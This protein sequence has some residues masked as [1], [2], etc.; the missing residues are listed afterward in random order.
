MKISLPFALLALTGAAVTL[1]GPTT[2]PASRP[3]DNERPWYEALPTVSLDGK[4][5]YRADPEGAELLPDSLRVGYLRDEDGPGLIHLLRY[6]E[7]KPVEATPT[8]YIWLVDVTGDGKPEIV[9]LSSPSQAC[10]AGK[11]IYKLPT[12]DGRV[13]V[14]HQHRKGLYPVY[15]V[16]ADGTLE[17]ILERQGGLGGVSCY[18]SMPATGYDKDG[19]VLGKT[20]Y[21]VT[22]TH[23]GYGWK[24]IYGTG[25]PVPVETRSSKITHYPPDPP[26]GRKEYTTTESTMSHRVWDEEAGKFV[27]P[28]AQ[29]KSPDA[30]QDRATSRPAEA[31]SAATTRPMSRPSAS[32]PSVYDHLPT[33]S[34]DGKVY[35]LAEAGHY[36]GLGESLRM[37]CL[38]EEDGSPGPRH[39]LRYEDGKPVE[40][41][42][43]PLA[44]LVD[45]TGDGKA[46]VITNVWLDD[47]DCGESLTFSFRAADGRRAFAAGFTPVRGR[48]VVYRIGTKGVLEEIFRRKHPHGYSV[49]GGV[50]ISPTTG[51]QTTHGT[52]VSRSWIDLYGNGVPVPVRLEVI[53][54]T[55][56]WRQPSTRRDRYVT[57][58]KT[59]RHHIWDEHKDKF[60]PGPTITKGFPGPP[61]KFDT[62]ALRGILKHRTPVDGT[63]TTAP[64]TRR[65]KS[66]GHGGREI[67]RTVRHGKWAYDRVAKSVGEINRADVG[68]LAFAG[69][70]IRGNEL[71]AVIWT[72]WGKLYWHGDAPARHCG[73]LPH[74]YRRSPPEC[75]EVRSPDAKTSERVRTRYKALRRRLQAFDLV[76]RYRGPSDN[77]YYSL[78]ATSRRGRR[79]AS[80]PFDLRVRLLP[81]DAWG[82]LDRLAYDG[83]LARARNITDGEIDP[84]KGPCY[85]L[86]VNGPDGILLY[87]DLGW[88]LPMLEHI[89]LLAQA[90]RD[91]PFLKAT[92]TLRGRLARDHGDR[93]TKE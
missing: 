42:G 39:L 53:T 62:E 52:R 91:H 32:A 93:Q 12:A 74:Y 64:A 18:S 92:D 73:W 48:S 6:V 49:L 67:L 66:P 22:V 69:K 23:Y 25:V 13:W 43:I 50:S 82:V 90:T 29:P 87:E 40:A 60:V 63:S 10:D 33:A 5:Y 2:H 9:C 61:Y 4:V 70:P 89:D 84:P 20:G 11:L 88:G 3:A 86:T 72:P 85:T 27:A 7:G 58:T 81:S 75:P 65:A 46:E 19:N 14:V 15:R 54:R 57:H 1:A 45:V 37:A 59:L 17:T 24:D 71:G 26:N 21:A 44:R 47:F 30:S 41:T 36:E 83:F 55:H 76:L 38:R 79:K 28:K 8:G 68:Q 31:D 56:S 35:Y 51:A 78:S 16:L 34:L 77:P 80:G